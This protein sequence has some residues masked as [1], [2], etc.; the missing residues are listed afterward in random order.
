M[1]KQYCKK[2]EEGRV[3]EIFH[4]PLILGNEQIYNPSDEVM[5]LL[6]WEEYIPPVPVQTNP[7]TEERLAAVESI[8][9]VHQM[10]YSLSDEKALEVMALFPAWADHIGEAV[11]A[12][13]NPFRTYYDGKLYRCLQTHTIQEDWTPDKTPALWV[14]V[15]IEEWPEWVQPSGAT[16]AYSQGDKVSHN[17]QHWISLIDGNVWEPS[18]AVPT[19]W[20][21]VIS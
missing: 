1:T 19:L 5:L 6:G 13:E 15:S 9:D 21:L 4:E 16:D 3:I 10:A 8:L 18:E 20:Q 12:G 14:E 2:D 11:E 7:T 17:S